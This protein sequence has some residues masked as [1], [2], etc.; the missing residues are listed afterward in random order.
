MA[1]NNRVVPTIWTTGWTDSLNTGT[2]RSAFPVHQKRTAPCHGACPVN[3]EI[4]IWIQQAK[5]GS[6]QEAWL[7]LAE[8]NPFPAVT[9]RVCHHP[10]ESRCNRGEYDG[11]VAINAMEQFIGDLAL[12]KGW[13]LPGPETDLGQKVAVIGGGPAGLS[14]AYQLR[15][16]GYRVAIYEAHAELGGML[17]YGI[18][19]YRL[20]MNVLEGE[21]NRLLALGFEVNTGRKVRPEELSAMQGEY[22]AV[23]LAIGAQQARRLPQFPE[24][25]RV[26]DGLSFLAA[27]NQGNLPDLGQQVTVIGG[28]S[29]AM[30]VA[31]CA[32][33]LGSQVKVLALEDN[34]HLPAQAEEVREALEEGITIFGGVLVQRVTS[35]NSQLSLDCAR[36]A[37]D[38]SA[39]QGEFRTV[40]LTE[41]G[42]SVDSD[43]I[44]LAVGQDVELDGWDNEFQTNNSLLINVQQQD[45]ST[46]RSGVYA[47][48]D[49]VSQDRFV[50]VAISH[51]KKA[52][53][54]I[55]RSLNGDSVANEQAAPDM[56]RYE[57]INT[58][59]FPMMPLE[60]RKLCNL[61]EDIRNFEEARKGFTGEQARQQA[62]RC[63]SCGSCI[64]CDNCV[65]FCPDMAVV[66]EP[67]LKEHYSI[68][69]QYCKGCG[70]C[71][72]ECPRGAVVMKEETK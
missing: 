6:Y 55:A 54:E 35:N 19:K 58:F 50:S 25:K 10:C 13:S 23:F 66:K 3:G 59:Y 17:R 36:V 72:E 53:D 15:R 38:P 16:R 27:V 12:E 47:G 43:N 57:E 28:G 67:A 69:G 37:L 44:I 31:R 60:N 21:I 41:D 18:P 61:K 29:V 20:P 63:F 71:V 42:L 62:E 40:M 39:P 32:K 70:C 24:D 48:G 2:W 68:L 56:V 65:Y 1:E 46:S 11:A 26:F 34:D 64:Q 9:G 22:A 45:Y 8:N 7:T 52:A 30:D 33:R 4:P 14:C 51:G 5:N 49:A